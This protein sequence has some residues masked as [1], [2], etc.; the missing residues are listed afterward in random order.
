MS[1]IPLAI[2]RSEVFLKWV[3]APHVDLETIQK[4]AEAEFPLPLERLHWNHWVIRNPDGTNALL[5]AGLAKERAKSMTFDGLTLQCVLHLRAID[6]LEPYLLV[7]IQAAQTEVTLAYSK[8]PLFCRTLSLGCHQLPEKISH[9]TLEIQKSVQFA[10]KRCQGAAPQRLFLTGCSA[11]LG[12]LAEKLSYDLKLPVE[13]DTWSLPEKVEPTKIPFWIIPPSQS[14]KQKIGKWVGRNGYNVIAGTAALCALLGLF[15]H[16]LSTQKQQEIIVAQARL[17]NLQSAPITSPSDDADK[18]P[19]GRFTGMIQ[20]APAGL[21]LSAYDFDGE[22]RSVS[23]K[24]QASNYAKV[25]EFLNALARDKTFKRIQGEKSSLVQI[26]D[27][28]VVDFSAEGIL[29]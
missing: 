6:L 15:F 18:S 16:H 20:K 22:R 25:S 10:V 26:N 2:P 11:E 13:H 21:Y 28:A 5:L 27:R 14:I 23:V 8:A 1:K 24:G 29:P 3:A 4:K 17:R 19:L 12:G 7:E 9:F